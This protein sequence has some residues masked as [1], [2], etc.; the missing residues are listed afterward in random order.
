MSALK[1][2]FT[3]GMAYLNKKYRKNSAGFSLIEMLIVSAIFSIVIVA[4]FGVFTSAIKEQRYSLTYQQ[5]LDQSSYAIDYMSK[6]IRMAKRDNVGDCVATGT[7]FDGN[8][9]SPRPNIKFKDYKDECREFSLFPTDGGQRV[10]QNNDCDGSPLT[11]EKFKVTVLKF[12]VQGDGGDDGLQPK[13][14]ILLE[15]E[16]SGSAPQPKIR[17]QT[18]VSQRNLDLFWE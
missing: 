11:S 10:C 9:P 15:M 14:T 3:I 1:K 17:I 5:M 8:E 16:G 12:V 13:V 6:L 4:A 2:I 7:N 18:T